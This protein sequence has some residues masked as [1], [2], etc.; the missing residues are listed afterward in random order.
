MVTNE[1]KSMA[2]AIEETVL[3]MEGDE[4]NRAILMEFDQKDGSEHKKQKPGRA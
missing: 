2:D 4:H 3:I 1:S